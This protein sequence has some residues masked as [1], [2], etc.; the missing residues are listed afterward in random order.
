M[1][2]LHIS[3]SIKTEKKYVSKTIIV[4]KQN[5]NNELITVPW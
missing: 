3:Q 5:N 2:L 1:G 4:Q